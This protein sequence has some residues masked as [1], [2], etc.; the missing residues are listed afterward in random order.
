MGETGRDFI[1][2]FSEHKRNK[3]WWPHWAAALVLP[4]PRQPIRKI[5][6]SMIGLAGGYGANRAQPQAGDNMLDDII[7]S[8]IF[9]GNDNNRYPDFPNEMIKNDLMLVRSCLDRIALSEDD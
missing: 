2:R 8:L 4:C 9:L 6:E 3:E 1:S 5:F 7:L